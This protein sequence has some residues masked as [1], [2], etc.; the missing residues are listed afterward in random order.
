MTYPLWIAIYSWFFIKNQR[1]SVAALMIVVAVAGIWLIVAP[2]G[3]DLRIVHLWGVA[4][5]IFGAAAVLYLNFSRQ[6]H[7]TQ[8]ILFFMFGLGSLITLGMF[9]PHFFVPDRVAL[10]YLAGC[11]GFGIAG[12]YFITLGFRY[13][14]AQE[15]SIIT[16]S[17]ILIA[18]LLGPEL[19]L[20][21]PLQW[22]GWC[23]ALLIF[24]A[25]VVLAIRKFR[26]RPSLP[27][28]SRSR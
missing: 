8:T 12:Q 21:A 24:S 9:F 15:G 6:H 28:E 3:I 19:A 17:R 22:T 13:V 14:T 23:G 18:A 20:E 2:K 10:G 7:D 27:R 1:D 16:S 26:R 5:G 4:S 11:A 25:N